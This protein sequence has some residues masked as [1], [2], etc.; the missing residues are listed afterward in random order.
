MNRYSPVGRR[1][2]LRSRLGFAAVALT[3][4]A[5]PTFVAL[6]PASAAVTITEYAI[7][8]PQ[9]P[10]PI[11]IGITTGPD[12]RLWFAKHVQ[13]K[14]GRV[15]VNGNFASSFPMGGTTGPGPFHLAKGPDNAVWFTELGFPPNVLTSGIGRISATG[16]Y[17]HFD[18]PD[19]AGALDI[20]NGPLDA[21]WFTENGG[22][23]IGFVTLHR[24]N[25]VYGCRVCE[26]PIPTA[27]SAPGDITQ[28]PDGNMWFTE[29]NSSKIGRFNPNTAQ[30]TEF[31]LAP[32][33]RPEGIV[34]GPDGN[35]WFT[36][37]DA[38]KI[39]R[40]TTAG[41]LLNE[42][43]IPGDDSGATNI[44]VGSDG[45]MWFPMEFGDTDQSVLGDKVVRMI[46][47]GPN[48]GT[49]TKFAT[50]TPESRPVIVTN[51]PDGHIWVTLN[52]VGK[53]AEVQGF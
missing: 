25:G 50:P 13:N 31:P 52:E 7:T 46:A 24:A 8:G 11:P 27:D 34:T 3:T 38:N 32:G 1:R 21:M 14:I 2:S 35:L 41:V 36:E 16:A 45:N 49:V 40:M 10:P 22:N 42:F 23:A 43:P 4:F 29:T 9:I 12:N 53:I 28:G 17:T 30:F 5:G 33:A 48:I 39:G 44:I 20:T 6:P 19:G 51:G 15:N 18:L 26:F 37:H 47:S